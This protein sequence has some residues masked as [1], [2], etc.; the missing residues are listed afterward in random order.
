MVG[1]ARSAG[2]DVILGNGAQGTVGCLLEAH[3]QLAAGLA[4]PGEMNG[5]LKI[6]RDPL[7][8]LLPPDPLAVHVPSRIDVDRLE[9]ALKAESMAAYPVPGRDLVEVA[10]RALETQRTRDGEPGTC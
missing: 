7:G 5:W 4:R 9:A 2:L 3:A 8:F 10:A 6:G 1:R